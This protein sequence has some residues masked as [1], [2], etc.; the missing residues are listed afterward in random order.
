MASGGQFVVAPDS[1]D[2]CSADAIVVCAVIM[3][4][5]PELWLEILDQG[6]EV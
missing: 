6:A 5:D 1:K 2:A 3:S 4:V